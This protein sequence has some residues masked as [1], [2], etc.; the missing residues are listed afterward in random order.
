MRSTKKCL[1][2]KNQKKIDF[3][4]DTTIKILYN[5]GIQNQE[6]DYMKSSTYFAVEYRYDHGDWNVVYKS[7]NPNKCYGMYLH[8]TNQLDD[9]KKQFRCTVLFG[10]Y[11]RPIDFLG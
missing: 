4:I 10:G 8:F 6:G 2:K 1:P 9:K 11:Y 3:P 7:D 5:T